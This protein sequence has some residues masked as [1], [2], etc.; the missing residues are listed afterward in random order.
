MEKKVINI[1]K[2]IFISIMCFIIII[3]SMPTKA[4][5]DV[6]QDLVNVL[7]NI[8]DGI[9]WLG[10]W[11]LADRDTHE[12]KIGI[13]LKG[14]H[15][16]REDDGAIYNFFVTPYDIFTTGEVRAYKDSNGNDRNFRNLP[17]FYANFFNVYE[18]TAENDSYSIKS[19]EILRPVIS[20]IYKYLRN[21]CLVLMM[22]VLLYIGIRIMLSASSSEQSKYK[23]MLI[24]WGVG[25][26]LLFIMHYIMSFIMNINDVVLDMLKNDS[27]ATYYICFGRLGDSSDGG[28]SS[29]GW[30]EEWYGLFD[31]HKDKTFLDLH[32]DIPGNVTTGTWQGEAEGQSDKTGFS[33]NE[34]DATIQVD[35]HTE[36]GDNGKVRINAYIDGDENDKYYIAVYRAN[37][38]EYVRTLSGYD[39][40]FITMY[41][42]NLKGDKVESEKGSDTSNDAA[43]LGYAIMY[44]ALVIETVMFAVIYFKR[45]LQLAF[46]TMI[47]PLVAF[48][49]PIDKIGDGKAQ[50]F[51]TWFKDYLFN[52]LIQPLHLL[53]YTI[54]VVAAID[55]FSKNILY[56]LAIYA[57]MIVAEKYF[58]KMFGF[59]KASSGGG[60]PLAGAIGGG[61]A[62]SGLN[63]LTGLGPPSGGG[64]GKGSGKEGGSGIKLSKRKPG[65]T[66]NITNKNKGK[67]PK[68]P[69]NPPQTDPKSGPTPN[70]DG[71]KSRLARLGNSA[72]SILG[73]GAKMLGRGATKV[74]TGGKFDRWKNQRKR[75]VFKA[76]GGNIARKAI[77]GA[78]TVGM[79]T[80]GVL[81]G[82]ATAIATGDVNNL[83][84][85]A[86]VGV[87]AG[88]KQGKAMESF[89]DEKW[90]QFKETR[91]EN[92]ENY[93]DNLR[94]TE[95]RK[96]FENTDFG[97]N[98]K[99][100][101]ETVD[102]YAPYVDFN[103]DEGK[104]KGLQELD[105]TLGGNN[106][107]NVADVIELSG[108]ATRHGN[109]N[110]AKERG[111]LEQEIRKNNATLSDVDVKRRVDAAVNYYNQVNK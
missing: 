98:E 2:K 77:R 53:L 80:A 7:L 31:E 100:A 67:N 60:G 66:T 52:V 9:M 50:A 29:H 68:N 38:M 84:K 111:E 47:A 59:D 44:L 61:M 109:V 93:R 10:N 54:F 6:I 25:L 28:S 11:F 62:M 34:D 5:A 13:G 8:P 19:N 104:V 18:D 14:V 58:K 91:S 78:T 107:D 37:L 79:A 39:A 57:F 23:N 72:K 40:D 97:D 87:A 88:L 92:D 16:V 32:L 22:L 20:N 83:F 106:A 48:M 3:F 63:K 95:A 30:G 110:N 89:A 36:W 43:Y 51:N 82:G 108:M 15:G 27:A 64:G 24:D 45:I 21:L 86:G 71:G 81:A 96:S 1:V 85:G 94:I 75:D 33:F 49:Y 65:D 17:I 99:G 12:V 42:N 70:S 90:Q 41:T 55:L 105:K 74:A 46:L 56:A 102:K 69:K 76:M 103:G 35:T 101:L 4:K 26:C 73:S